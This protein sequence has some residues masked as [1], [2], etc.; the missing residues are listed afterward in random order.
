LKEKHENK[1]RRTIS[2]VTIPMAY[3]KSAEKE[4]TGP[5]ATRINMDGSKISSEVSDDERVYS[6]VS[7]SFVIYF[8]KSDV[9]NEDITK[10]LEK[11]LR[12]CQ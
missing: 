8:A 6:V 12:Q 7:R 10:R 2:Q 9:D 3:L 4:E 1:Y 11:A 5:P